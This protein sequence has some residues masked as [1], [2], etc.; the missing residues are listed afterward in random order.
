[1]DIVYY[2]PY[3]I[4]IIIIRVIICITR[5]ILMNNNLNK[6]VFILIFTVVC[7]KLYISYKY[8]RYKKKFFFCFAILY[9]RYNNKYELLSF[10]ISWKQMIKK[11]KIIKS[12]TVCIYICKE[13]LKYHCKT[14]KVPV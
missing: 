5:L 10:E 9:N 3:I 8:R 1:M 2:K 6:N 7:Y 14:Y 11:Q 4:I 12:S 13:R